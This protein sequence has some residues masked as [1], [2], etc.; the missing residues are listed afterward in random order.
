MTR[1]L[2]AI[3]SVLLRG[4]AAKEAE[5]L[6]LSGCLGSVGELSSVVRGQRNSW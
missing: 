1:K 4:E 3:P 5:L 2:L 6:V